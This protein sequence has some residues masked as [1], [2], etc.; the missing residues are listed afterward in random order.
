MNDGFTDHNSKG[1][2]TF[3]REQDELERPSNR[4]RL[5]GAERSKKGNHSSLSHHEYK[6]QRERERASMAVN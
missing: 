4:L 5:G 3:Y 1:L 2:F 6:Q